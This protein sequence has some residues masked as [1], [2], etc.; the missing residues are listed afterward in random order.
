MRKTTISFTSLL[1]AL[2]LLCSCQSNE[3]KQLS[4]FSQKFVGYI[5]SHNIDSIRMVYPF[6]EFE[7]LTVMDEYEINV[8]R[9]DV[10][11]LWRID[12]GNGV[13]IDAGFTGENSIAVVDSKGI[14][15]FPK[16]KMERARAAGI[17]NDT[18]SDV[19]IQRR[20]ANF[21]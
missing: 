18:L 16:D 6:A 7:S 20:L 14:A 13:W 12:F 15:A 17:V 4:E 5:A 21:N 3:Q 9:S 19:A 10:N 8:P 1:A 11:G 2:L